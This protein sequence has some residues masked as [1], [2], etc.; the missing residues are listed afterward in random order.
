MGFLL[1]H[2]E[3]GERTACN[4]DWEGQR[5]ESQRRL[6][7]HCESICLRLWSRNNVK[8][9]LVARWVA[10]WIVRREICV[11]THQYVTFACLWKED[12]AVSRD[13]R[14]RACTRSTTCS[15][16]LVEYGASRYNIRET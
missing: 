4:S 11:A 1:S 9:A 5:V 12:G 10:G 13:G 8:P 2:S 16:S 15:S 14:V 7:K 3:G 6:Q